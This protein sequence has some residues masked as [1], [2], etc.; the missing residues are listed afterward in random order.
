[1]LTSCRPPIWDHCAFARCFLA[2]NLTSHHAVFITVTVECYS[3][4]TLTAGVISNLPGSPDA[5]TFVMFLSADL[6]QQDF[7]LHGVKVF[8]NIFVNNAHKWKKFV[9]LRELAESNLELW[10]TQISRKKYE[11]FGVKKK[12]PSCCCMRPAGVSPFLKEGFSSL[13][14]EFTMWQYP[15]KPAVWLFCII[16]L[17]PSSS[18]LEPVDTN[19]FGPVVFI[20]VTN[21]QAADLLPHA[22]QRWFINI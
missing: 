13:S 6:W 21:K 14:H 9:Q 10:Y 1:M 7:W 4:D 17:V 20:T 12:K 8:C 5:T 15:Q 3:E 19:M 18:A 2:F 11:R 22:C 16:F